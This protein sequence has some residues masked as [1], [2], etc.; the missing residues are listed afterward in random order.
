MG[1]HILAQTM[2]LTV[3]RPGA[4]FQAVSMRLRVMDDFGGVIEALV[5]RVCEVGA[6]GSVTRFEQFVRQVLQPQAQLML[7][8]DFCDGFDER[9]GIPG[10][11]SRPSGFAPLPNDSANLDDLFFQLRKL[12]LQT[13]ATLNQ[14][15]QF[16]LSL[17]QDFLQLS[18]RIFLRH[19]WPLIAFQ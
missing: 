16:G 19:V 8:E 10:S 18:D 14:N 5:K 1:S 7:R 6:R 2:A 12:L 11:P 17:Q 4:L 9:P 3:C 15:F 13:I